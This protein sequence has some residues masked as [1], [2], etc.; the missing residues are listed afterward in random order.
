MYRFHRQANAV[1]DEQG[2]VVLKEVDWSIDK[3]LFA[4]L[5]HGDAAWNIVA[6]QTDVID[7]GGKTRLGWLVV[8]IAN[9]GGST[10]TAAPHDAIA[11]ALKAFGYG[12]GRGADDDVPVV[13][14]P[15][16]TN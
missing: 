12:N 9:V 10:A 7:S 15:Q 1:C 13:I 3:E 5:R 11:S 8:K 14:A 4:H 6:V 2:N 16:A